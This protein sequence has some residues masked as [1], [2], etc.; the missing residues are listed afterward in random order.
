MLSSRV[1]AARSSDLGGNS[2]LP[3]PITDDLLCYNL[4]T[5]RFVGCHIV[6]ISESHE[7]RPSSPPPEAALHPRLVGPDV[8]LVDTVLVYQ[9]HLHNPKVDHQP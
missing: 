1:V 8:D 4:D 2:T 6:M 5:I 9:L 3:H 7:S